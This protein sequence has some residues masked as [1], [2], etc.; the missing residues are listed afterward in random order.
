MSGWCCSFWR[1]L[2]ALGISRRCRTA[3]LIYLTDCPVGIFFSLHTTPLDT[4]S[5]FFKLILLELEI[6][7]RYSDTFNMA[8]RLLS[9]SLRAG[10]RTHSQL[11][12]QF[13]RC[14]IPSIININTP[15]R[16]PFSASPSSHIMGT[17]NFSPE[18][19]MVRDAIAKICERFPDV[20]SPSSR[21]Y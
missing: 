8:S 7:T 4:Q 20:F 1:G 14:T 6:D 3:D 2:S 5:L 15:Q 9:R 18:Q 21:H 12:S 17:S 19:L 16:R 13:P 10:Q 11:Q